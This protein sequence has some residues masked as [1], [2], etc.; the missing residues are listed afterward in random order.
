MAKIKGTQQVANLGEWEPS[1]QIRKHVYD[2]PINRDYE[3]LAKYSI[4]YPGQSPYIISSKKGLA[5]LKALHKTAIVK[6]V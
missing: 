4:A 1:K 6:R 2:G 3:R 5:Q